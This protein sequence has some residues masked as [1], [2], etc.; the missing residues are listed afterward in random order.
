MECVGVLDQITG[1]LASIRSMVYH[2]RNYLEIRVI[3]RPMVVVVGSE[4]F[5]IA[6]VMLF[7]QSFRV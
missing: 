1:W 4:G 6:K 5:Q 2:H 3:I 7:F